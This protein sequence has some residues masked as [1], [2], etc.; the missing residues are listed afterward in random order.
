MNRAT[1]SS[2]PLRGWTGSVMV[3][4]SNKGGGFVAVCRCR[5]NGTRRGA[6]H[7]GAPG[8][9]HAA[10]S[11]RPGAGARADGVVLSARPR[12]PT[13]PSPL[14]R[15][16]GERGLSGRV[17]EEGRTALHRP[18][19]QLGGTSQRPSSAPLHQPSPS[20]VL[21]FALC[22]GAVRGTRFGTLLAVEDIHLPRGRVGLRNV[23]LPRF[24]GHTSSVGYTGGSV[25]GAKEE[26]EFHPGVKGPLTIY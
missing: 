9:T 26:A 20:T 18:G 6:R 24:C 8:T 19:A 2:T 21:L 1:G 22:V 5:P 25:H 23:S 3:T 16:G 11:A 13:C 7:F 15:P 17:P 14:P 12:L 10:R 4:R